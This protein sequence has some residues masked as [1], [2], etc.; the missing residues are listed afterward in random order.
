MVCRFGETHCVQ[1]WRDGMCMNCFLFCRHLGR[2]ATLDGNQQDK[3]W[4][5][6]YRWS[7]FFRDFWGDLFFARRHDHMEGL[8]LCSGGGRP[9]LLHLLIGREVHWKGQKPPDPTAWGVSYS[10]F[11]S[12]YYFF[13]YSTVTLLLSYHSLYFNSLFYWKMEK[14]LIILFSLIS[15]SIMAFLH[16]SC[17]FII[18]AH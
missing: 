5:M 16:Y 9:F 14:I 8:L 10:F 1:D 6:T 12:H 7:Y 17:D 18:E 13:S 11:F 2:I 3:W 15:S 4:D